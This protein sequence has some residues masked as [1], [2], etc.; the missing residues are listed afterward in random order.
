MPDLAHSKHIL[1]IDCGTGKLPPYSVKI[2]EI[3]TT[4]LATDLSEKM[5]EVVN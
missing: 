5:I 3:T 1:K 2:K 4:Y